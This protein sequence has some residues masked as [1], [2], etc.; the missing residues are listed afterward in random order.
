MICKT[1]DKAPSSYAVVKEI[2]TSAKSYENIVKTAATKS[3]AW[4]ILFPNQPY[5]FGPIRFDKEVGEQEAR[6][7]AK[8]WAGLNRLPAGFKCWPTND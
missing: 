7:W 4:Y 3:R 8:E 2:T 6:L 5:A 1:F